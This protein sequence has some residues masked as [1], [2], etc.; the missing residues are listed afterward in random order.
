MMDFKA[1]AAAIVKAT[2]TAPDR[3]RKLVI[4]AGLLDAY[5]AG[6]LAG[7]KQADRF[8]RGEEPQSA[9]LGIDG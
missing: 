2:K 1:A 5:R 3:H 6:A 9:E 7:L 4:A 8:I